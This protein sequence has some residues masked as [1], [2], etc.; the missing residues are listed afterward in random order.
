MSIGIT[1]LPL[2]TVSDIILRI[3]DLDYI[4]FKY[5][6][7]LGL[8]CKYIFRRL[9]SHSEFQS[10]YMG[11]N[12]YKLIQNH[13]ENESCLIQRFSSLKIKIRESMPT[14]ETFK[15]LVNGNTRKLTI[16]AQY[17][18]IVCLSSRYIIHCFTY[19]IE[20]HIYSVDIEAIESLEESPIPNL[21]TL[22]L[23]LKNY[24]KWYIFLLKVKN[25]LT[26][27]YINPKDYYIVVNPVPLIPSF[28]APNLT[29]LLIGTSIPGLEVDVLF[30]THKHQL[31]S[32]KLPIDHLFVNN[33][34]LTLSQMN[35]I[36][37]LTLHSIMPSKVLKEICN[38]NQL[39]VLNL[40][41]TSYD[42]CTDTIGWEKFKNTE[43]LKLLEWGE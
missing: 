4:P 43:E 8:I 5:K 18:K 12:Q 35:N 33:S 40:K 10:F 27:L 34:I 14:I 29:S 38:L 25:S 23:T 13:L 37:S 28:Y 41:N 19:L 9:K 20:L 21:K 39:R 3:L 6:L 26:S 15:Q 30:D 11:T 16:S 17:S 32:V 1:K 36:E 24:G 31:K 22:E 42:P 7:S 2:L